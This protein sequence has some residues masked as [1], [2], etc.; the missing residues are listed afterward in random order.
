MN[1]VNPYVYAGNDPVTMVDTSGADCQSAIWDALWGVVGVVFTAQQ[2]GDIVIPAI[3]AASF[4]PPAAA[5]LLAGLVA[6]VLLFAA[7]SEILHLIDAALPQCGISYSF[8][9]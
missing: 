2:L 6:W 3:L 9:Y 4:F 7:A 1:K 8:G 5:T